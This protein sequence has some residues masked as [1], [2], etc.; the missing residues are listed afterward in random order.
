MKKTATGAETSGAWG[1][2]LERFG[3]DLRRRGTAPRTQRAYLAD[4][5]ELAAWAT[6]QGVEPSGLTHPVLRPTGPTAARRRRRAP[7]P[8]PLQVGPSAVDLRRPPAPA[9]VG[10]P[11]PPARTGLAPRPAPFLRH[12]SARGRRRSALDPR[13]PRARQ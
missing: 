2:G 11:R 12:P 13:A 6:A 4:A 9:R 7:R 8:L 1:D 10:A 3:D 5:R